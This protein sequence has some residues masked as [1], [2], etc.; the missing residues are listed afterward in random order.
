MFLSFLDNHS[1]QSMVFISLAPRARIGVHV[2]PDPLFLFPFWSQANNADDPVFFILYRFCQ[3]VGRKA[4][5]RL[6]IFENKIV[7]VFSFSD[8][9]ALVVRKQDNQKITILPNYVCKAS[10]CLISTIFNVFTFFTY[11]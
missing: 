1:L 5:I 6:D 10:Y 4:A 9:S 3:E 8:V 2:V 11:L 7:S